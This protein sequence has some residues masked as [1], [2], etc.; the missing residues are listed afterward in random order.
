MRWRCFLG[1]LARRL[2]DRWAPEAIRVVP[3]ATNGGGWTVTF[4]GVP[5][6][7]IAPGMIQDQHVRS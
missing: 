5:L 1:R 2:A 6:A 7:H 3:S 4:S